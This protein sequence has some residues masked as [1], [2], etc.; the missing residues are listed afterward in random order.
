MKNRSRWTAASLVAVVALSGCI[1]VGPREGNRAP[2][3][4]EVAFDLAGP[5][6][7]ALVVP[8]RINE[9]GPFPFVLDTGATVTCVDDALAR[10]L[11]LPEA[12]G[13]IAVGG[14]VRGLGRMRMLEIDAVSLGDA[15][16]GN[17]QGCA[18]DLSP[19][20]KAGLDVRGLLG[21]NFLRAYR[22]TIDF[23]AGTVRL[24]PPADGPPPA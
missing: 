13:T 23:T 11:E 14:G 19:M 2:E 3:P 10:E 22:V 1:A 8:V 24:D 9:A 12:A 5:G 4:G 6:G 17:L 16:V 15:T 21:L 7:A 18:V 20:Q